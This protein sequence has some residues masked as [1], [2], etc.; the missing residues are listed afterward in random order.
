MT[1][2]IIAYAFMS[3]GAVIGW[4]AHAAVVREQVELEPSEFTENWEPRK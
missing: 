2:V 1:T 4:I 3:L